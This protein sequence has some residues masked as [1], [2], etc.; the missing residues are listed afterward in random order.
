MNAVRFVQGSPEQPAGNV[1]IFA[2]VND[3]TYCIGRAVAN[4]YKGVELS[5]VAEIKHAVGLDSLL[6][7]EGICKI[8]GYANDDGGIRA[9]AISQGADLIYLEGEYSSDSVFPAVRNAMDSYIGQYSNVHYRRQEDARAKAYAATLA[10]RKDGSIDELTI[11]NAADALR[12]TAA[13]ALQTANQ[14]SCLRA[15]TGL[16]FLLGK[17]PGVYAEHA[18]QLVAWARTSPHNESYG[19]R[20]I[21]EM[22]GIYERRTKH[23][24]YVTINAANAAAAASPT[25]QSSDTLRAS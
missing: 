12:G 8:V 18:S 21:A 19:P 25:S 1:Y 3:G 11:L 17:L 7:P 22:L 15:I 24:E 20:L 23:G 16:E 14:E 13:S 5:I 6:K 4:V 10:T 2:R 9:Q